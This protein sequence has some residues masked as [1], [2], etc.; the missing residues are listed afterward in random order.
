MLDLIRNRISQ[1]PEAAALFYDELAR[2]IQLGGI[3][4]KIEVYFTNHSQRICCVELLHKAF[5]GYAKLTRSN[6]TETAVHRS[7]TAPVN[8]SLRMRT[9]TV[10]PW[11][12]GLFLKSPE[13]F[14]AYFEFHNCLYIFVTLRF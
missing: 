2:I 14:R 7:L 3:D 5:V 1:A 8:M 9:V 10:T 6:K 13:T 12:V 11:G 4:P